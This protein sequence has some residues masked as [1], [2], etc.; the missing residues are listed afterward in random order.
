MMQWQL[1]GGACGLIL[2]NLL[3]W[4]F[5]WGRWRGKVNTRLEHL[6]KRDIL[7]ECQNIFTGI[8]E[9]LSSVTG[10]VDTVLLLMKE[11]QKNEEKRNIQGRG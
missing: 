5:L 1:V 7:P 3:G 10:K 9:G 8:K 6:E 4:V 11:N 2:A